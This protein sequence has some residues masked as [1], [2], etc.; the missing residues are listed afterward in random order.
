MRIFALFGLIS[1]LACGSTGPDASQAIYELEHVRGV[2]VSFSG[3]VPYAIAGATDTLL[4][5]DGRVLWDYQRTRYSIAVHGVLSRGGVRTAW[6]AVDS[7]SYQ[8]SSW[9]C[10][11]CVPFRLIS[12]AQYSPE[13]EIRFIP[14]TASRASVGDVWNLVGDGSTVYTFRRH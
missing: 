1:V 8:P 14:D 11:D 9:I 10:N 5:Q 12:D 4:I 2:L 3:D 7:G 6:Q 13:G